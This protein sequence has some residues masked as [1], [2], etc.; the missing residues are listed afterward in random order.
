MIFLSILLITVQTT[1]QVTSTAA[2]MLAPEKGVQML[3]V[4]ILVLRCKML[5]CL[6][7]KHSAND[8]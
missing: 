5:D 1:L 6:Q 4:Q 8:N 2:L 3:R 7:I